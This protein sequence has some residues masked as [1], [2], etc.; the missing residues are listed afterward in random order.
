MTME[1]HDSGLVEDEFLYALVL[2]TIR[3]IADGIASLGYSSAL[4]GHVRMACDW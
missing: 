2:E 1:F 3:R 4:I